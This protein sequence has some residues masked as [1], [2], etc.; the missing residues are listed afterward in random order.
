MPAQSE[1]F[2]DANQCTP[3]QTENMKLRWSLLL[4]LREQITAEQ[5]TQRQ[6]ADKLGITQPRISHL[7]RGRIEFFAIDTLVKML[8]C[9]GLRVELQIIKPTESPDLSTEHHSS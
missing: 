7:M 8:A 3:A 2:R 5:L 1:R 9:A 6:A 4:A